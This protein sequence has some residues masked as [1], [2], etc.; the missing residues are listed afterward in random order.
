M[1]RKQTR[2]ISA[3]DVSSA[4]QSGQNS[5]VIT[6]AKMAALCHF[7][8]FA[9]L[10]PGLDLPASSGLLSPILSHSKPGLIRHTLNLQLALD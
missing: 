7:E 2:S 3:G 6:T 10:G 5:E 9:Q 8:S 4:P 1:R